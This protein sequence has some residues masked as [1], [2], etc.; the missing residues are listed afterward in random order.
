MILR[1]RCSTSYDLASLF[2]GRRNIFKTWA[3]VSFLMLPTWKMEEVSQ[4]C[5]VFGMT[6]FKTRGS[7]A[8]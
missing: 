8:E 5:F 3:D 6:T 1:D 2:H 7:L 4:S